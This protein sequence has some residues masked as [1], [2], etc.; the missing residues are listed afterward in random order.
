MYFSALGG[1]SSNRFAKKKC[2]FLKIYC[3]NNLLS[4]SAKMF[5]LDSNCTN[6]NLLVFLFLF[7]LL[8]ETLL[9]WR[10]L[11]DSSV[12]WGIWCVQLVSPTYWL[13]EGNNK[14]KIPNF[15]IP[16]TTQFSLFCFADYVIKLP[17]VQTV[18]WRFPNQQHL[19][20]WQ[21]KKRFRSYRANAK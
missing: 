4:I 11:L 12:K 13:M 15:L 21:W 20:T 16:F 17:L 9:F 8:F 18:A 2:H 19:A 14:S 6:W 7:Y 10:S 5:E 3:F 1:V